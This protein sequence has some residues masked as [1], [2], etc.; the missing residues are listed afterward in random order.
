MSEPT[1]TVR[2]SQGLRSL[3]SA[4][5]TLSRKPSCSGRVACALGA[6]ASA[7]ANGARV[8]ASRASRMANPEAGLML[9]RVLRRMPGVAAQ[10]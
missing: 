1:A 4:R 5:Y 3:D 9:G 6:V 10:R 7:P 2:S 8:M